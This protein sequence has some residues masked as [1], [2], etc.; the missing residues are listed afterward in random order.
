MKNRNISWIER[1]V[2]SFLDTYIFVYFISIETF[3]RNSTYSQFWP[4][5]LSPLHQFS[6]FN[7]FLWICWFLGKNLYNFVPPIGNSTIRITRP[8]TVVTYFL[9]DKWSDILTTPS[10]EHHRMWLKAR[11]CWHKLVMC[12]QACESWR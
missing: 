12:Q 5:V 9:V 1:F 2:L 6:K 10:N 7:N 11:R 4:N 8:H 3:I